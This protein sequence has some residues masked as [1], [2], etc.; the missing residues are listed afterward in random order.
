[1]L[2]WMADPTSWAAL[3]TLT[4][5]E[6]VLGIDN[7]VFISVLVAK[8][9][10]EQAARA[11]RIGLA[12]AL[13]FRVA[14]L[15]TL[16]T[17]IALT[18]PVFSIFGQGFSWRDIVLIAGGLFLIAKA[19]HEIHNEMEDDERGPS[20][21]AVKAAFTAA[22]L[23]IALIDLVFSVD[24]IITAIGMA[25]DVMIMI[26]AV[27]LAM[28][29]M[30]LASGFVSRFITAHPTTKMLALSFLILIGISL[31]AEGFHL[32]FPRGYI[33]FAML[34]AASVEAVNIAVRR[35][36]GRRRRR[37]SSQFEA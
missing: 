4:V 5:M 6:I 21:V 10:V 16:T 33:Y 32:H 22:I 20:G 12:L 1:M 24:S 3:V 19:T 14:L 31:V 8:L 25:D 36:K 28:V 15:F 26:V 27:V 2:D 13:L 11:R 37:S 17:I 7:V 30:Y 35:K 18:Q 23:Q 34:F 9:P 29:V